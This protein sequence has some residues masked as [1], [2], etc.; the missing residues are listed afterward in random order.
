M[1]VI[2][3][4]LYYRVI[5]LSEFMFRRPLLLLLLFICLVPLSSTRLYAQDEKNHTIN[6]HADADVPYERTFDFTLRFGMGGFRDSRSPVGSLGGDE[7]ALDIRSLTL[8]VAV[9]ISSEYYTNSAEPTHPYE[10]SNLRSINV[11][12]MAPLFS[13]EKIDYFLGGGIGWLEVPKSE[14]EPEA[15]IKD[16]S[17]NLEAGIHYRYFE[18]W[19]FYGVA[20][21]LSAEKKVNNIKVIDFSER[22]ILL[23]ITY[24]FSL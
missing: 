11:L 18:K 10:I 8:P 24:N 20:K 22:I 5:S 9:S 1:N 12:Y 16:N 7:I 4:S 2:N 19:G 3:I 17:Y 15:R 14:I 21:Y 13:N 23:G 6:S